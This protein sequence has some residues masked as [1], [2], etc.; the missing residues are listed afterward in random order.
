[1][2]AAPALCTLSLLTLAGCADSP[3][4]PDAQTPSAAIESPDAPLDLRRLY[5]LDPVNDR[6]TLDGERGIVRSFRALT[7]GRVE[8][9]ETDAQT[10]ETLGRVVLERTE[11]GDV[12]IHESARPA[13]DLLTRFDPP[14][15]FAPADLQPGETIEQSLGVR[16]FTLDD[17]PRPKSSGT[18]DHALTR[19]ADMADPAHPDARWAVLESTLRIRLGPAQVESVSRSSLDSR[20][21]RAREASRVVRVFGLA[22]ERESERLTRV[23]STPSRDSADTP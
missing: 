2:R 21:L 5:P 11:A 19:A 20:G 1:M 8:L 14:M 16:T 22:V 15:I 23:D 6:Y 18:A 17:P 10:R 9:T 3:R 13:R 4:L 12:V 7:D